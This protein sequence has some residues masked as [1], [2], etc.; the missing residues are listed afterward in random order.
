MPDEKLPTVVFNFEKSSG[1]ATHHADGV[2]GGTTPSGDVFFAFYVE[3]PVIPKLF[4][5]ELHPDG[6]LGKLVKV[7]GRE[8][9]FRE[10]QTGVV[11]SRE[12]ATVL[13]QRIDEL[14][15]A[16]IE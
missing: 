14:L 1:Y 4:E 5:Q 12:A 15:A 9:I 11:L 2:L 6:K 10:I 7:E 8:G 16:K 3:R 13:R